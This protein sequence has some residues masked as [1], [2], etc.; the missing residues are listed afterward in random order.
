MRICPQGL[1]E[2][3]DGDLLATQV[4]ASLAAG[5]IQCCFAGIVAGTD[6]A[7]SVGPTVTSQTQKPSAYVS[8]SLFILTVH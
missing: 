8:P 7:P 4:L 1:V 6:L 3:Q 2:T 5:R